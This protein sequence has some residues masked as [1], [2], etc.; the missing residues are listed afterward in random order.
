[1]NAA[2]G[3]FVGQCRYVWYVLKSSGD[4]FMLIPTRGVGLQ[5]LGALS[6]GCPGLQPIDVE[7]P[8][9]VR[10][11]GFQALRALSACS[12]STLRSHI[13]SARKAFR[14]CVP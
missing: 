9:L 5:V 11:E 2:V 7:E 3:F 12:A 8:Q 6:A 1:M 10:E 14:H 4:S 13:W